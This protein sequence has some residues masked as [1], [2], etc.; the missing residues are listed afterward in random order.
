MLGKVE[1]EANP[2]KC[3]SRLLALAGI[4]L[5]KQEHIALTKVGAHVSRKTEKGKERGR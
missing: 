1:N 2:Q 5:A 3:F 4:G